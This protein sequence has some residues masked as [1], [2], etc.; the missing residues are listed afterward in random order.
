VEAGLIDTFVSNTS[1]PIMYIFLM[2][3][4]KIT[5][6]N[7]KSLVCCCE[8]SQGFLSGLLF[9]SAASIIFLSE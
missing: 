9:L 2:L 7:Q 8:K 6:R 5:P 4:H 3:L 1:T